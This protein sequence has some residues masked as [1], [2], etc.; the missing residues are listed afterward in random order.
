MVIMMMIMLTK[1]TKKRFKYYDFWVNFL[2][3]YYFSFGQCRK[4]KSFFARGVPLAVQ[5]NE[6]HSIHSSAGLM[7]C[8]RNWC[9]L[10]VQCD[11]HQLQCCW[12]T[13]ELLS[14]SLDPTPL[15]KRLH[16]DKLSS[17]VKRE[18]QSSKPTAVSTLKIW[19][20]DLSVMIF[21]DRHPKA[22]RIIWRSNKIGQ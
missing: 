20:G 1:I 18:K 9:H 22:K 13:N 3:I 19:K 7:D 21:W 14:P 4:K 2:L 8:V 5:R 16:W 12:E 11:L 10:S 6:S 17:S 15:R